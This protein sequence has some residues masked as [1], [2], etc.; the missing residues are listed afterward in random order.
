MWEVNISFV[1][2]LGPSAESRAPNRKKMIWPN[3]FVPDITD[4]SVTE[5][6]SKQD[7]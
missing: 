6:V 4:I 2:K 5:L 3:F 1:G 7:H